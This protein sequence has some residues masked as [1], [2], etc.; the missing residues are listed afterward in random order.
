MAPRAPGR[1]PPARGPYPGGPGSSSSVSAPPCLRKG[2]AGPVCDPA[3]CVGKSPAVNALPMLSTVPRAD[4]EA[5]AFPPGHRV[6]VTTMGCRVNRYDA[7]LLRAEV[8]ALG[9]QVVGED[10]PYDLFVLNTCTVTHRADT[11]ARRLA[12]RAR[13]RRPAARVVVTGCYAEVDPE[14]LAAMPEIDLVA[15]NR[16]KPELAGRLA[17]LARGADAADTPPRAP[18]RRWGRGNIFGA[19]VDLLP[20]AEST[21]FFLKVQEG[22]DQP[23]AYCIIPTARGAARSMPPDDV[24]AAVRAAGDAGYREVVLAG[25]HLG[26]YG[27]DLTGVNFA[28]LLKRVLGETDVPRIRFGSLEPWGVTD[29]FVKLL[30]R[31]RR[32][33]PFLH[34]PLQSGAA[35][36]L[37]RMRRPCTPDFYRARVEAVLAA[38]PELFLSTD[39]LT[40]F[41]GETDAEFAEGHDFIASLPFAHLHVFPYSARSGT[42]AA[43]LPDPVPPD[44]KRDR[45]ARL[46]D[47]SDRLK[48]AAL[49]ARVGTVTEVLVERRRGGHAEDGS[50]VALGRGP[51]APGTIVRARITG[52]EGER[53]RAVPVGAPAGARRLFA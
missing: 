50:A 13:R 35:S 19:G 42:P 49:A 33:M 14:A 2:G 16:D 46:I 36:V 3:K 9:A 18:H 5:P 4:S 39:V 25:I 40:G 12:R 17:A 21:R 44:V 7:A 37:R 28:G 1:G 38:R 48:A 20:E 10:G 47:L 29:A 53:L 52:V 51:H 6:C 26:G 8:A 43:G 27:G 45:A 24:V 23:C 15:G 41:P 31:E 11:E 22:C 30:G 34:L 32:L